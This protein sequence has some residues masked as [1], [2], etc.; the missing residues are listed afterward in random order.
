MLPLAVGLNTTPAL[1][2][3]AQKARASSGA[4]VTQVGGSVRPTAAACVH[5]SGL[6][7]AAS[8]A[9]RG[10]IQG[11]SMESSMPSTACSVSLCT[12]CRRS[13][14][15]TPGSISNGCTRRHQT[16][17]TT[18]RSM[19]SAPSSRSAGAA[20]LVQAQA[21]G[22]RA[23][24]S[25]RFSRCTGSPAAARRAQTASVCSSPG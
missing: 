1:W 10:L 19:G 8:S 5:C 11:A 17:S 16:A 12:N 3:A 13:A 2:C 20:W 24:K 6:R 7:C 25:A 4:V 15:P 18:V 23:G 9:R 14:G 21:S 22:S